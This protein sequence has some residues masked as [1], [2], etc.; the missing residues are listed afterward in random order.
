MSSSDPFCPVVVAIREPEL[1]PL[2]RKGE[3]RRHR[4]LTFDSR[5]W[6]KHE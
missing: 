5:L 2:R 1:N 6:R 3:E 4:E